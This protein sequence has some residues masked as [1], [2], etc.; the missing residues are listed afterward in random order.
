MSVKTA[1]DAAVGVRYIT[2][3]EW[4]GMAR[5]TESTVRYWRSIGYGPAGFRCGRRVLYDEAE[6]RAF[7]ASLHA[8]ARAS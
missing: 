8:E 7:L 4:A 6:C 5:T 2:S 3:A 1:R